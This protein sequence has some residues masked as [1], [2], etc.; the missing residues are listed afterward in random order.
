M[1]RITV[2][3]VALTALFAVACSSSESGSGAS[4]APAE[5]TVKGLA[6]PSGS[7]SAAAP[8]GQEPVTIN[9]WSFY[10][11]REFKQY[12]EVLQDFHQKYPWISIQ[13]TGGKSDQDVIRAYGANTSP[14]LMISPGPDNVAKFCSSGGYTDL[15]SRL[16]AD[17]IDVTSII[18]EQALAYSS[19]QGNQC[20]LPVLSDAYGLYYNTE[21]FKAAGIEG[22]PKTLSELE[23]D[24]KKLTTFNADGSIKVAGFVP[25][26]SWYENANFYN[27]QNTGSEY[28][29]ANG[30]SAF[31]SDPS[32]AKL[33]E[34]QKEFITNVYGADGYQK[35]QDFFANVGGPDSEWSAAHAFETE[36]VAMNFDG[37][38][39]NA[40]VTDDGSNVKYAT[41][42][43]PVADDTPDLY[44]AGQIGGDV[45][46]IPSNGQ[47]P[48][49]A[50][51][52][53]KY[54]A[55]DTQAEIKLAN[56]LKNV[57][58]TLEA[59]KDPS[60]SGDPHFKPFLDIF[61]NENSGYKQVTPIGQTD[62]D[63][64]VD[65]ISKWES[66][67]VSDLQAGLQDL[68]NQIDQQLALG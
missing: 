19:Y 51:L 17:N 38:W 30:K 52:L 9:L 46:G 15:S 28:Y 6:V 44:G 23:E 50:W 25:L 53:L 41:A 31:A 24:A 14:D 7:S 62:A 48:D 2:V 5:C 34:W 66:G 64:W 22:P 8:S 47:Q 13:H 43:F 27:G 20:T 33:M 58:T 32:W 68:A 35:L 45:L 40:F 67:Q 57:P 16:Q 26:G 21:M 65:F 55:T 63:L 3:V 59:L 29:D 18:P 54:L 56:T 49:A 12:C 39:R 10:A 60:L 61:A 4:V 36:Q 1:K 42:P 37:E 11:G